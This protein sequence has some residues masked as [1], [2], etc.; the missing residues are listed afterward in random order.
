LNQDFQQEVAEIESSD[1]EQEESQSSILVIDD[2]ATSSNE[3]TNV[4]VTLVVL[5]GL[6]DYDQE[7]FQ[8][9][10]KLWQHLYHTNRE[11]QSS[12]RRSTKSYKH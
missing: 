8:D 9:T 10:N 11:W 7:Y 6:A 2:K 5:L 1:R 12:N 3:E 4:A